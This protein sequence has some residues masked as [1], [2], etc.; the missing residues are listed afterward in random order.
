MP[1]GRQCQEKVK[2]Q[3]SP[4]FAYAIGLIAS[5]GCLRKDGCHIFLISKDKE[6]IE[7]FKKALTIENKIVRAGRGGE[8]IKRYY[9]TEFG[10]KIF[11]GFLNDIGITAAKSRTI[12]A[13]NVPNEY[14]ADFLRGVFDGDGTF[15]TFWDKRWPSS[16]GYHISFASASED[17]AQWLKSRLTDLYGVKGFVKKGSGV[18][19]LGYVKGDSRKLNSVMYYKN[20]LLHLSRKYIKIQDAFKKDDNLKLRRRNKPG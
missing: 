10:D 14:F 6:M 16:F 17:Y 11:Y 2:I 1:G 5:D 12:K 13:V 20:D 8:K 18:L 19:N 3:W 9:K 4:N 7:N 15:Y